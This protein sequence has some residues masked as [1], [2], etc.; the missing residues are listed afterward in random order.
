M[1][2]IEIKALDTLFFR[3][4]KPFERGEESVANGSF[5]PLPSVVYGALRTAVLGESIENKDFYFNT[6]V[7]DSAK[8]EI[9]QFFLKI[10]QE[11][12]MP[13][14]L[15]LVGYDI[16]EEGKTKKTTKADLIEN[17]YPKPIYSSG[18]TDYVLKI[19]QT[20]KAKELSGKYLLKFSALK[21]YLEGIQKSFTP[22]ALT[23]TSESKLGIGRNN[24][25][26]TT[27]DGL[28]YRVNMQR[29]ESKIDFAEKTKADV[30]SLVIG[31][32]V[33]ALKNKNGFF[34]LGGEGKTI[35]YDVYSNEN[36][37]PLIPLNDNR[38]K[39]YLAT[40]A[41]FKN[42]YLP[43]FIQK[44]FFEKDG[45]KINVR[46]L[47]CAIGKPVMVG[48]FDMDKR[49]PKE[50]YKA[51]PA[52]A[53]YY[54]E[55]DSPEKANQLATFLHQSSISELRKN[56]GFGICYIGRITQTTSQNENN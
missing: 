37:I 10:N 26:R 25:S 27:E 49:M 55:T 12:F 21:S 23:I 15:D 42:G 33:V 11:L 56:E 54:L 18:Q 52:G 48:G 53:V 44:G 29:L 51:V 16:Q 39:I 6:F 38:L 50:M 32:D 31:F 3:D 22:T 9:K 24:F 28:L 13:V 7:T 1:E 8:L 36:N 17:I 30:I 5:P 4:G 41:I 43:D 47:T 35:S 19:S 46:L 2:K 14:P 45:Q 20:L 40:P 34:K